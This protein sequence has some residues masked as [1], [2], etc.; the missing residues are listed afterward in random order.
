MSVAK[1]RG[2]GCRLGAPPQHV[3]A[4]TPRVMHLSSRIEFLVSKDWRGADGSRR[5]I[6]GRSCTAERFRVLGA[7]LGGRQ[8]HE[9]CDNQKSGSLTLCA[10]T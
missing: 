4:S 10:S 7:T 2:S 5:D 1:A 3:A 6:I 8:L 9:R